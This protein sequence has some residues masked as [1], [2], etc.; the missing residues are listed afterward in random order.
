[1]TLKSCWGYRSPLLSTGWPQACLR[2]PHVLDRVPQHLAASGCSLPRSAA[3]PRPPCDWPHCHLQDCP[4]PR[5]TDSCG[6]QTSLP[7]GQMHFLPLFHTGLLCLGL[8]RQ[9][10]FGGFCHTAASFSLTPVLDCMVLQ[11]T[12]HTAP[13]LWDTG[14]LPLAAEIEC[15]L[16]LNAQSGFVLRQG[17]LVSAAR[18]P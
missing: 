11:F 4:S 15:L 12:D 5:V 10:I 2:L 14:P 6:H 18:L 16:M 1:M 7:L 17:L 8:M 3:V 9:D 13:S